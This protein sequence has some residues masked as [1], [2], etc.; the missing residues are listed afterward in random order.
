[1][2]WRR[3][4]GGPSVHAGSEGARPAARARAAALRA[5]VVAGDMA[6]ASVH[7][8]RSAQL[9]AR[10]STSSPPSHR[11]RARARSSRARAR[12][13]AGGRRRGGS[14]RAA[15]CGRT[16]GRAPRL[17]AATHWA[18]PSGLTVCSAAMSPPAA[19]RSR[20]GRRAPWRAT[21]RG[22]RTRW[23]CPAAGR[24]SACT[25]GSTSPS[26]QRSTPSAITKRRPRAKV[27]ACSAAADCSGVQAS[28]SRT[29]TP[30]V[31]L[32][33]SASARRRARRSAMRPWSSPWMR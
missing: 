12:G 14:A 22:R 24:C 33:D 29:S 28:P 18:A 5:G 32:S 16:R 26:F 2:A 9:A 8:L 31:P 30:P 7:T 15:A 4:R 21:P 25:S 1:M 17:R 19:S 11:G 3:G 10:S 6:S 20:A 13:A 23:W 27:M